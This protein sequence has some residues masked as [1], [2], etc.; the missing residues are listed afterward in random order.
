MGD[1]FVNPFMSFVTHSWL[2]V[3]SFVNHV[4]S[5]VYRFDIRESWLTHSWLLSC[6]S[7]LIRD[8]LS[9]LYYYIVSIFVNHGWL[10]RDSVVCHSWLVC[11]SF[12]T[13]AWL[14][15]VSRNSFVIHMLFVYIICDSFVTC[16]HRSWL[17]FF[18][19]HAGEV[20]AVDFVRIA[21]NANR[22]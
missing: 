14:F 6:H 21:R 19:V 7:W 15:H 3:T 18:L 9:L 16:S 13:C 17:A 4:C 2:L 12:V 20:S 5:F 8:C 1:S 11:N 22:R 10:I